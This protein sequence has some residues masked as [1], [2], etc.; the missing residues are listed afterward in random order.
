MMK[1]K[2]KHIIILNFPLK[3]THSS[4]RAPSVTTAWP[5]ELEFIVRF[6]LLFFSIFNWVSPALTIKRQT[7]KRYARVR[8]HGQ[9]NIKINI[10]NNWRVVDDDQRRCRP[11]MKCTTNGRIEYKTTRKKKHTHKFNGTELRQTDKKKIHVGYW[12][13][14]SA[15][16]W[17]SSGYCAVCTHSPLVHLFDFICQHSS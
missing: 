5:S 8:A 6:S 12:L 11:T 14:V 17:S 2:D 1:V 10:L 7:R 13:W 9:E 3:R 16:D 4:S 15:C